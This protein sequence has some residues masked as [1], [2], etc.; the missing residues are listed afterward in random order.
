MSTQV[1]IRD[2]INDVFRGFGISD[3]ESVL[4]NE[5]IMLLLAKESKYQ[6]EY[7]QFKAKYNSEF[8]QFREKVEASGK[9]DF[10]IDDDLM[11]WEFAANALKTI[12]QKRK[13]LGV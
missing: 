9:E 2:E 8:E 3:M 11:D 4:E 7:N 1:S 13:A 12:Q 10:K 6:A 5:A